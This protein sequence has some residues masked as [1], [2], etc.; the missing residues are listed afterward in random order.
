V[1]RENE[2]KLTE[3]GLI[4]EDWAVVTLGDVC[5]KIGSGFTP[6]GAEKVYKE[7]GTALI[8][9]QNVYNNSFSKEGLVFLDESTAEEME[10]VTLVKDDV[11]LNITGDSVARCCTVPEEMLP[12]R[13]NQHVSIIRTR[14]EQLDPSFL[15][16]YLTSPR[17]QAFMLSLAQSGGTRNA[18]TKGMIEGFLIPK[19]AIKE[20]I[21]ITKVLSA[22]D[23]KIELNYKTNKTL[24]SIAEAIFKHWFVDFEFPNGEGKPYKFSNGEMIYNEELGKEIPKGWRL[25]KISELCSTQYGYTA[26]ASDDNV[27][28]KFLRV[29]DMNKKPWINWSEVPYCAIDEESLSRYRL[30]IGDVLVSRM[31]DPGKAA[32]VEDDVNAVFASYLIRL[33]TK[34]L[35]WSYYLFYFLR[36]RMYLDYVEGARIGSVQSSMNA[37]VITSADIILPTT[38][39]VERFL[40]TIK[41]SRNRIVAN[42]R[43]S[44]T[45][46]LIRNSLLPKLM[47]GKIRVPIEVR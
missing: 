3:I 20:Q 17:M 34:S 9:S 31:A 5:S 41:P 10:N 12:A 39:I 24:E 43:Q 40:A 6:R 2:F 21:L 4:P 7:S 13:V 42:L 35:A 18:L 46:S 30:S 22:L 33:K 26:S 25:N 44:N 28:P 29:T 19:P 15:R 32:I 23:S 38:N 14:R 45:L 47:S 37:K 16:Y 8:R 1:K 27:G 11:L 36:S